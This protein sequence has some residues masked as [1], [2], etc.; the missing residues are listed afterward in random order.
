[1]EECRVYESNKDSL[2]MNSIDF[3]GTEFFS[4]ALKEYRGVFTTKNKNKRFKTLKSNIQL[5]DNVT[6]RAKLSKTR[7]LRKNNKIK[8]S[9]HM[10][11]NSSNS[12]R[13]NRNRIDVNNS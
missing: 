3:K 9:S 5:Q 4:N 11:H 2:L 8:I 7:Q 13:N 10:N 12:I 1:M 6:K